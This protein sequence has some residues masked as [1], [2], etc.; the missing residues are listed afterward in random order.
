MLPFTL[1]YCTLSNGTQLSGCSSIVNSLLSTVSSS[2]SC[3][4]LVKEIRY[5][6]SFKNPT[7]LISA[8]VDVVF[9]N[10]AQTK[11]ANLNQ[12]FSVFFIPSSVPLV[13]KLKFFYKNI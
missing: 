5:I 6:L 10:D 13:K 9:F 1:R 2:G 7:G 3:T 8:N 11:Q 12:Y 4:N